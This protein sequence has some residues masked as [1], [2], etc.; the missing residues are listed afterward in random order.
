ME[1]VYELNGACLLCDRYPVISGRVRWG[2][3][4][5][6]DCPLGI[7]NRIG[8]FKGRRRLQHA[9]LVP[10]DRERAVRVASGGQPGSRRLN[11]PAV[12]VLYLRRRE[13]IIEHRHFI[14]HSIY[15]AST[16]VRACAYE[17]RS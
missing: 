12:E 16:E 7:P 5:G 10:T 17:R 2:D 11:D 1:L 15:D 9:R 6:A 4:Y 13:R 3:R 8:A 14:N